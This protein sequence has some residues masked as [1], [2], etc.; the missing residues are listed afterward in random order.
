M[1][2]KLNLQLFSLLYLAIPLVIF[3]GGYL[4]VVLAL[5]LT[6][7]FIVGIILCC[8]SSFENS[9]SYSPKIIFAIVIIAIWVIIAGVGG[10]IWQNRWDH[11]F[12]NALFSD[13]VNNLWPVTKDG[14]GLCYYFGFWMPA[15]LIGKMFGITAGYCFQV[16]WAILGIFLAYLLVCQYFKKIKIS[17]L[18]VFIIFS[19]L[20]IIP[21][22]IS[23]NLDILGTCKSIFFGSHMELSIYLFNSS[24]NTTLLFWLYNQC[25][26]FWLGFSLILLQKNAKNI[27]LIYSMMFLFCPFPC[28]GLAPFIAYKLIQEFIT[29]KKL[30]NIISFQ[31]I[32]AL[33]IAFFVLLF[34]K[35]NN[36]ANQISFLPF[37][38]SNILKFALFLIIEFLV[39]IVLVY[40][41][42]RKDPILIVLF[43]S[44]IVFSWIKMGSSY[45]FAWRTCIPLSFYTMLLVIKALNF[46]NLSKRIKVALIIVLCIG[47]I[48]PATEII[49]TTYAEYR[50]ITNKND[51]NPRSD[52]LVSIFDKDNNACYDNFTGSIDSL[53][54]KY[55]AKGK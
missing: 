32:I 45:D 42:N 6:A 33:P 21:Y 2:K 23:K 46:D 43:I 16:I 19:G 9:I 14:V 36:S 17:Y 48:T 10:F 15:A 1:I 38:T 8:R 28:V 41:Y 35:T 50:I 31:N 55:I 12:R 11:M 22:L 4:K 53:F 34:F 26:P 52:N 5:P 44:T 7:L 47:A 24:S 39:Y 30:K 49:R 13:L 51:E 54:Y 27:V 37:S 29:N 40:R 3:F 20:D 18:L 25:I